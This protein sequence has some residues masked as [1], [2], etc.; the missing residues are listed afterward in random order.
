LLSA[1]VVKGSFFLTVRLWFDLAPW[2]LGGAGSVVL[3]LMAV[4]AIGVGGAMALRQDRLKLLV[5]YS[6]V[7]Q[8]GYLFL[9]FPVGLSATALA[10]GMFQAVAHALAKAAM[11]LASGLLAAAAGSDKLSDLRGVGRRM[12]IMVL[13]FGLAALSL[14]GVP[15]TGGFVAKWLLVSAA[16]A[17]GQWVWAAAILAGGLLAGGYLFRAL[18]ALCAPGEA[19]APGSVPGHQQAMVLVLALAALVLG[20]FPEAP[21]ELLSIGRP[22]AREVGE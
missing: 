1:L 22:A 21:L 13:A 8:I 6:T 11:F 19:P 3:G 4:G 12:P 16:F 5:A 18:A 20:L 9:I 2:L 10:G 14:L 7:A 15:P 17:A